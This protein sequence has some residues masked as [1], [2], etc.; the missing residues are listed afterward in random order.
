VVQEATEIS[1]MVSAEVVDSYQVSIHVRHRRYLHMFWDLQDFLDG[2]MEEEPFFQVAEVVQEEEKL[3][4]V[5][6][7]LSL[8][9]LQPRPLHKIMQSWLLGLEDPQVNTPMET[10]EVVDIPQE[11]LLQMYKKEVRILQQEDHRFHQEPVHYQME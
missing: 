3:Q 8:I 4:G 6:F 5:D 2:V 7:V 11:A 10:E 1:Q 9:A